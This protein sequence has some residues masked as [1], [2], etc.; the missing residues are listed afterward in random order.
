MFDALYSVSPILS[1]IPTRPQREGR[2]S[3][4]QD[5]QGKIQSIDYKPISVPFQRKVENARGMTPLEFI[6]AARELGTG[7]G[8]EMMRG[9][10]ELLDKVT[11]ET[12]NVV[13]LGGK[14]MDSTTFLDLLDKVQVD[15]TSDGVP[16]WPSFCAGSEMQAQL[17]EQFPK[18]LADPEFQSRLAKIVERKREEFFERETCRRLV[19]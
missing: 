3:S 9:L 16:Q 18:W 2:T 11:K 7:M 1:K 12:G 8:T 5:E 13:N 4:F 19:D 17:N 6:A 15:F 10:F 14:P